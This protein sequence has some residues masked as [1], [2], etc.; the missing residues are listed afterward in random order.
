MNK[1]HHITVASYTDD[2]GKKRLGIFAAAKPFSKG[3]KL[4]LVCA[5]LG[6]YTATLTDAKNI[7]S[8]ATMEHSVAWQRSAAVAAAARKEEGDALLALAER[9]REE[10]NRVMVMRGPEYRAA[11]AALVLKSRSEAKE[12][13]RQ[14]IADIAR[15]EAELIVDKCAVLAGVPVE[16]RGIA[17]A[18][19]YNPIVERG[20]KVSGYVFTNADSMPQR[21]TLNDVD[22]ARIEALPVKA[23]APDAAQVA[24]MGFAIAAGVFTAHGANPVA[25]MVDA[26]GKRDVIG[27]V[28]LWDMI[29]PYAVPMARIYSAMDDQ[30]GVFGYEVAEEFGAWFWRCCVDGQDVPSADQC[31]AEIAR[32]C[33]EFYA[34]PNEYF[35]A[36]VQA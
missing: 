2:N 12:A 35:A 16:V 14:Q 23:A 19:A 17:A 25:A 21:A 1:H 33:G 26:I 20:G 24:F 18:P 9:D 7:L 15:R 22:R 36:M 3:G 11:V 10:Y 30:P 6:P 31:N 4:A 5:L 28:E 29:A 27:H 13:Q 8:G 32:L 34:M